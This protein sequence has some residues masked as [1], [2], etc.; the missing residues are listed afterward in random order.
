VGNPE[1]WNLS[2]QSTFFA[3]T[4]MQFLKRNCQYLKRRASS[5]VEKYCQKLKFGTLRPFFKI[6]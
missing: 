4:E 3:K 1:G 6:R 2:D 5:C